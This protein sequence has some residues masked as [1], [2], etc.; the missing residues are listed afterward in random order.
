MGKQG[1]NVFLIV[2]TIGNRT[3]KKKTAYKV[4]GRDAKMNCQ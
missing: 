3:L 1:E 4:I 2:A